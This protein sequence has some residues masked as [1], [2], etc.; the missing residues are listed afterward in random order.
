M[1][2]ITTSCAPFLCLFL[3]FSPFQSPH[4]YVHILL[5]VSH[6][7]C[8]NIK[9]CAVYSLQ[10][11][12]FSIS[13]TFILCFFIF[14]LLFYI[15]ENCQTLHD[16]T[17][18]DT[19]ATLSFLSTPRLHFS[20]TCNNSVKKLKGCCN[21]IRLIALLWLAAQQHKVHMYVHT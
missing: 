21:L 2:R 19:V 13:P 1:V 5:H 8:S 17:R 7:S 11:F 20:E 12:Y 10:F 15:S 3:R 18:Q 9:P 6:G 16:K 14:I 4:T